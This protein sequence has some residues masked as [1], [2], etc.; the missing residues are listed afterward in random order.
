MGILRASMIQKHINKNPNQNMEQIAKELKVCRGTIAN[1]IQK[2]NLNYQPKIKGPES[3]I[4]IQELKEIL[5]DAR[6][7]RLKDIA[8][9]FDCSISRISVIIKKHELNYRDKR[10]KISFKN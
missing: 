7:W 8:E 9:Y 3:K 2:Y 10:K 5:K 6:D 1:F 4:D